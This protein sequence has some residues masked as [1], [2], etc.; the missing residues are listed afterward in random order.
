MIAVKKNTTVI[1]SEEISVDLLVE[2]IEEYTHLIERHS[3][4]S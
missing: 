4:R 2:A 3:T 1:L